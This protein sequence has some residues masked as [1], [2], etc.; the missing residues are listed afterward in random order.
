MVEAMVE[1]HPERWVVWA[2]AGR[3]IAERF[4]EFE[5]ACALSA[6]GPRLQPHLAVPWF[7]HGRVLYLSGRVAEAIGA[8]D[9]GWKYVSGEACEEP[10]VAAALWQGASHRQLGE[11][12]ILANLAL[13]NQIANINLAQQNALS[14]QQAMNQLAQSVLGNAVNLVADLSPMEAVAVVK[15]DTGNDMAQQLMDLQTAVNSGASPSPT[16]RPPGPRPRPPQVRRNPSGRGLVVTPAQFPVSLDVDDSISDY[17]VT[18][19]D[20]VAGVA[21]NSSLFPIY[22][23]TGGGTLPPSKTI[24][25]IGRGNFPVQVRIGTGSGPATVTESPT[26]TTLTVNRDMYPVEVRA[27]P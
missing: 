12:G 3:A 15:L 20:G 13:A 11:R 19:A 24:S 22:V 16:P 25:N 17:R 9:E 4:K 23:T 2:A 14:N 27:T 26:G 6:Q 8:L 5:L 18:V 7:E 21:A 10:F 1:S